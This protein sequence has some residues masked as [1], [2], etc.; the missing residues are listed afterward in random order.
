[1]SVAVDTGQSS[2]GAVAGASPQ[3]DRRRRSEQWSRRGSLLPA[4]IFTIVVTQLPFVVTLVT[5]F[6]LERLLEAFGVSML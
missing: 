4:L 6:L 3:T 1:M 2:H 5:S